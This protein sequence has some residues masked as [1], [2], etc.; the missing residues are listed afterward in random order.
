MS[1]SGWTAVHIIICREQVHVMQGVG[2]TR[3]DRI[4]FAST[5]DHPPW[6]VAVCFAYSCNLVLYQ[7][8]VAAVV[9]CHADQVD[10]FASTSAAAIS[11]CWAVGRQSRPTAAWLMAF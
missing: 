6:H 1:R 10:G 4:V 7:S 11:G 3:R 5:W 8:E 2:K 9:H